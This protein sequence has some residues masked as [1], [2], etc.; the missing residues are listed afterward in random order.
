M[1]LTETDIKQF[2][3][4]AGREITKCSSLRE[5]FSRLAKP[6]AC[7]SRES[8]HFN[9]GARMQWRDKTASALTPLR[10]ITNATGVKPVTKK[11]I[12]LEAMVFIRLLLDNA[13]GQ[14]HMENRISATTA[15]AAMTMMVAYLDRILAELI[16]DPCFIL[17][18][19]ERI[20]RTY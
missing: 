13:C 19:F 17:F 18:C 6:L 15:A 7:S 4:A 20:P 1:K 9:F 12:R 10:A 3:Q 2:H 14:F 16:D 11:C 8:A 5:L